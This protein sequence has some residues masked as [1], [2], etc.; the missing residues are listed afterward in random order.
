MGRKGKENAAKKVKAGE[1]EEIE[2]ASKIFRE[3]W[4]SPQEENKN[5]SS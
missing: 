5:G 4:E 1:K 3:V 2:K